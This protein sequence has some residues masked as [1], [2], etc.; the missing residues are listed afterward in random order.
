MKMTEFKLW[1]KPVT[2]NNREAHCAYCK[3]KISAASMGIN[4][5][6]SHMHGAS[7]KAAFSSREQQLSI[8][9]FCA[10]QSPVT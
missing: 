1:L 5:V 7:H 2:E 4:A 10:T 9:S 8:A 3:K 6:K